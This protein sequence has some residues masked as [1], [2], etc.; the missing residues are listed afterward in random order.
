MTTRNKGLS[1]ILL[2][3]VVQGICAT[4]CDSPLVPPGGGGGGGGLGGSPLSATQLA[5]GQ[6]TSCALISG[7]TV[8]CWGEEAYGTAGDGQM[9]QTLALAP[10]DTGLTGVIQLSGSLSSHCALKSDG[11]IWCW[12]EN[13]SGELGDGT[14]NDSGTPVQVQGIGAAVA[15]S[16]GW[17]HSCAIL[18]DTSVWCWGYDASH[19]YYGIY[20]GTSIP[21]KV[22]GLSGVV[23][24][25]TN[26]DQYTCALLKGGSIDCWG[27]DFQADINP[28]GNSRP[29]P[30]PMVGFPAAVAIASSVEGLCALTA[31]GSVYCAGANGSGQLGNGSLDTS[32]NDVSTPVKVNGI[33]PA[34]GLRAGNQAVCAILRDGSLWCWG[35]LI[36]GNAKTLAPA[37]VTGIGPVKDVSMGSGFSCAT[38]AADNSVWCWGVNDV[39]ELGNGNWTPD[40]I[41]TP[42][43]VFDGLSQN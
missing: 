19:E 35:D 21:Y 5:M 4:G 8:K 23:Q 10:T 13:S 18:K 24:V 36:Y 11:S 20:S 2:V 42:A 25:D 41:S 33:G 38:Q 26:A 22:P 6:S 7:G 27:Y 39:A 15:V 32:G 40:P 28:V 1:L 37:Q 12:G 17:G 34:A 9:G 29:T 30:Y 14:W 16:A 31:T 43:E 3:F